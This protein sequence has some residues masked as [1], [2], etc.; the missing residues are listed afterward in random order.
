VKTTVAQGSKPK[1]RKPRPIKPGRTT[2]P[3]VEFCED[4]VA[5]VRV[6]NYRSPCTNRDGQGVT[7]IQCTRSYLDGLVET[8]WRFKESGEPVSQHGMFKNEPI[9]PLRTKDSVDF[10]RLDAAVVQLLSLTMSLDENASPEQISSVV[11]SHRNLCVWIEEVR[12]RLAAAESQ[13][14]VVEAAVRKLLG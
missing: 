2:T 12:T 8:R 14:D 13:V 10:G 7:S 1:W 9:V 4:G 5:R 3:V 11:S 6:D